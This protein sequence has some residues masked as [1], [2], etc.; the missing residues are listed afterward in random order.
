MRKYGKA[1]R[2]V[3]VIEFKYATINSTLSAKECKHRA[4]IEF[5]RFSLA[6]VLIPNVKSQKCE[7]PIDSF[8]LGTLNFSKQK[9]SSKKVRIFAM[10]YPQRLLFLYSWNDF[11][12]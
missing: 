2:L 1:L 4:K 9:Y 7:I 11:V 6:Y 12:G 8:F 10:I 3:W 5:I